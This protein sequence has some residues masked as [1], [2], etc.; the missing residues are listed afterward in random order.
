MT[1]KNITALRET[2]GLNQRQFARLLDCD[3]QTVST[4]EKGNRTP[5]KATARLL[6]I[7]GDLS[8]MMPDYLKALIPDNKPVIAAP[9]RETGEATGPDILP[10]HAA[11]IDYTDKLLH[12]DLGGVFQR[13]SWLEQE[14][15]KILPE[16]A[17]DRSKP[18][19]WIEMKKNVGRVLANV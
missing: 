8:I 3:P 2:L 10:E 9:L 15:R 13:L 5:T 11:Y 18:A 16:E 7:V 19:Y 1:P 14:A 4:W 12:G 17:R 6:Q